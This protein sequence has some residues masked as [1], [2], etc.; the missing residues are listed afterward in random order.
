MTHDY[1]LYFDKEIKLRKELN[2]PPFSYI[3]VLTFSG[4]DDKEAFNWS[5]AVKKFIFNLNTKYKLNL[6]IL[7]PNRA[8]ISKIKNK[9]RWKLIMKG[10]NKIYILKTLTRVV[11]KFYNSKAKNVKLS[12]DINPVSMQ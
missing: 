8:P 1:K 12:V 11:D 6:D 10:S 5:K 4:E 7:G 9:Y 2:Y 3:G